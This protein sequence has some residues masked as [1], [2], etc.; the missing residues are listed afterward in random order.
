M[1]AEAE[2]WLTAIHAVYP[3]NVEEV[4]SSLANLVSTNKPDVGILTG[5]NH[6]GQ[7]A[8]LQRVSQF[9]YPQY[10]RQ[11]STLVPRFNDSL[12]AVTSWRQSLNGQMVSR[13][14]FLDNEVT[15]AFRNSLAW[16]FTKSS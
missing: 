5:H 8:L 7:G 1:D 15:W 2:S 10:K 12:P 4:N 6:V 13:H 3:N 9:D 11:I 16:I 14:R